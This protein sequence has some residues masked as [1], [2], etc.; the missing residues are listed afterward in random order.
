[1]RAKSK[2]LLSVVTVII[3]TIIFHY[4]GWLTPIENFFRRL[5]QPSSKA[6]YTIS[7]NIKDKEEDFPSVDDIKNAY[8]KAKNKIIE[9]EVK[10][11]QLD[12]LK[13]E[14]DEL[15][16]QL[17]FI[18]KNPFDTIGAEV[19]GKNI[20]PLG[21]TIILNRGQEDGVTIN[22][23]VIVG[24]AL[25][26]GKVVRVENNVSIV[27]LINDNQ[28][29]IA[30]TVMGQDKSLGLVEGGYGISVRMN[31]IPQNE[32]VAI[33][34]MVITS[35]L[36]TELPKGLVIGSIATVEKEAY[37]PFQQAVLNSLVDLEKISLVSIIKLP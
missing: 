8:I 30:A 10:I 21:N 9:Q 23:P 2:T 15:R 29:K 31:Y 16:K 18:S 14:N 27:R 1:M 24:E 7:I 34:D 19:I 33:G 32:K 5:I 36:E 37:Q 6:L 35:G 20:D 12:I 26:V 28:S 17:N 13:Q 25:L 11:V 4:F 22:S 3:L